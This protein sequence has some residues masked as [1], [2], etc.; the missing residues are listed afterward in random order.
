MFHIKLLQSAK[1]HPI[2]AWVVI[3]AMVMLVAYANY[4]QLQKARESSQL[5][6]SDEYGQMSGPS[7]KVL[8]LLAATII[9]A[10]VFVQLWSQPWRFNVFYSF[11]HGVYAETFAIWLVGFQLLLGLVAYLTMSY[12]PRL[13]SLAIGSGFFLSLTSLLWLIWRGLSWSEVKRDL[14]LHRGEGF[15]TEIGYGF[16]GYLASLPLVAAAGLFVWLVKLVFGD[17]T[18][19]F[20]AGASIAGGLAESDLWTKAQFFFLLTLAAGIVEETLFR[21]VLYRHLR[22]WTSLSRETVSLTVSVT[23]SVVAS[24]LISAVVFASI[25]P[26]GWEGM[27]VVMAGALAYTLLR[28]YRDSLISPMVAHATNNAVVFMVMVF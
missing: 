6:K 17:S 18:L 15:G 11:S 4:S 9:G 10:I 24:G 27:L 21:G 22:E 7:G 26:Y 2:L 23:T 8:V 16:L 1:G 5:Q 13:L 28:E 20:A 12:I 25:H 3:C 14:G 19:P